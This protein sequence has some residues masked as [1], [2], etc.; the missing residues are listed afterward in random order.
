MT[1]GEPKPAPEN[2]GDSRYLYVLSAVKVSCVIC[3]N[4]LKMY[5]KW[6]AEI[7]A[8]PELARDQGK[9]VCFIA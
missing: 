5:P 3:S 6:Y 1:V 2:T 7:V 8:L 4:S 9:T